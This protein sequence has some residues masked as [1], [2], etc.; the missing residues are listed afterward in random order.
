MP[1]DKALLTRV[2][3]TFTDAQGNTDTASL[4]HPEEIWEM[5]R[6][7]LACEELRDLRI[8]NPQAGEYSKAVAK[9]FA[10]FML[11]CKS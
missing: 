5:W 3:V 11:A 8:Q 2:A 9:A 6:A 4:T 7:Y 1:L 10:P